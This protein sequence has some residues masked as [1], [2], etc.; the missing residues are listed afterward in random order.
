MK[1]TGGR[2]FCCVAGVD[3]AHNGLRRIVQRRYPQLVAAALA[4]VLLILYGLPLASA[5][6]LVQGKRLRLLLFL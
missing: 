3:H 6:G 4:S 1:E 5:G 2:G